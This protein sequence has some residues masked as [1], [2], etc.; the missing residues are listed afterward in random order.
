MNYLVRMQMTRRSIVCEDA[1][2]NFWQLLPPL[3]FSMYSQ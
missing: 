1:V 2:E 3:I